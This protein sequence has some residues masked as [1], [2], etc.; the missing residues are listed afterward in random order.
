MTATAPIKSIDLTTPERALSAVLRDAIGERKHDLWFGAAT[1]IGIDGS[2]VRVSVATAFA[3]EWIQRHFAD[4]L[5]RCGREVLRG[6]CD[7]VIEAVPIPDAAPASTAPATAPDP[8]PALGAVEPQ[9]RS[10]ANSAPWRTFAGFIVGAPNRL[11]FES[12]RHIADA[13]DPALRVL[14]LHGACGVG[15]THLLQSVCRAFHERRPV[16]RLRYTTGEQFTNEFVAAIRDGSIDA[17]RRRMRK[18]DL[19]AIDDVHFLA[20]KSATQSECLHTI[21]AIGYLGSKVVIASDAHPREIEKMSAPLISRFLAGMVV[22]VGEP[23][24]ATRRSL[25]VSLAQRR[26]LSFGIEA[27]E[28]LVERTGT[29]AREIEGAILTVVALHGIEGSA[30]PI[31][32]ALVERALGRGA[33]SA[34]QR[35]VRIAEVI[36]GVCE[37]SGV[38]CADLLGSGRHRRVVAARGL[39]AHLAREMTMLSFPEI[40][41]ALGRSTHSTVHAAAA[42]Y[43]SLIEA[44]GMVEDANGPIGVDELLDRA[45]RAILQPRA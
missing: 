25:A 9:V 43:R 45:R 3:S 24:L 4:D 15:K 20:N 10:T 5:R 2:T 36:E 14:F 17:Y 28:A 11:A 42:R 31:S 6:S 23:D 41:R 26:G 1:R 34:A 12:A 18:L 22:Q 19:L 27:L 21:D 30:A 8:L 13:D 38:Q 44:G 35:P 33:P 37:A 32:R 7:L 29:T 16:A 40:A 39:A